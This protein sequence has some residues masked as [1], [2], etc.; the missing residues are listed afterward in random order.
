MRPGG[1][2]PNATNAKGRNMVSK[3]WPFRFRPREHSPRQAENWNASV[4]ARGKNPM[5]LPEFARSTTLRWTVLVA[6]IFA[7]ILVAMVGFVSRGLAGD[8]TMRSDRMIASQ[9]GVFAQLSREGR[10][11]AN[12]EFLKQHPG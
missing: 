2:E 1:R 9:M 5:Q 11:S 7:A 8:V 3:E 12:V 10:P 6:A 4:I